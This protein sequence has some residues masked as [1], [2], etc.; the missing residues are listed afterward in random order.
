MT[1]MYAEL[2]NTK[3]SESESASDLLLKCRAN[4]K[5]A[6]KVCYGKLDK[7]EDSLEKEEDET[8]ELIKKLRLGHKDKLEGMEL[9][10]TERVNGLKRQMREE[11]ADYTETI[12]NLKYEYAKDMK[13]QKKIVRTLTKRYSKLETL[14]ENNQEEC[15]DKIKT[16]N[17]TITVLNKKLIKVN[18][19]LDN[20]L[21]KAQEKD[22]NY[23]DYDASS[24]KYTYNYRPTYSY[25]KYRTNGG[26]SY[27]NY[28]RSK[29]PTT[30]YSGKTTYYVKP[31]TYYKSYYYK[32][33]Y[34]ST[35]G[36]R[37]NLADSKSN[38]MFDWLF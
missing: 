7:C 30:Y 35:F 23:S 26:G 25:S 21:E 37:R 31:K 5:K 27:F 9:E 16:L 10:H 17:T 38:S 14:N 3:A 34:V 18:K 12:D 8:K 11:K 2:N 20:A 6:H 28:A 32:Y 1:K 36:N 24:Y 22:D 13:L 33:Y 4:F 15:S 29:T 19:K